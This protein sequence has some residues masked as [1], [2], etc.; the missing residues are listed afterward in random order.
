M[1]INKYKDVINGFIKSS[2][3]NYISFKNY[4]SSNYPSQVYV[5][6]GRHALTKPIIHLAKKN[7]VKFYTYEFS[8]YFFKY[9]LYENS[10]PHDFRYTFKWSKIY[11]EKVKKKKKKKIAFARRFFIL[12][13]SKISSN[14]YFHLSKQ[15][16]GKLPSNWDKNKENIVIFTSS[17]FE[18]TA[19]FEYDEGGVYKDQFYRHYV[20]VKQLR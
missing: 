8:N 17:E 19:A 18:K 9:N 16:K 13:S 10:Q 6:N 7:N 14:T 1:D 2:L 4:L 12:N 11:E 3:L 15:S 5:F 20:L